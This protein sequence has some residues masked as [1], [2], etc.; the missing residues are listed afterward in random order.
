MVAAGAAVRRRKASDF[1]VSLTTPY[2]VTSFRHEPNAANIANVRFIE[3]TDPLGGTE[4]LEYQWQTASLSPTAPA[5]EVPAGFEAW[6][7]RG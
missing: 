3:A 7:S 1:V 5:G 4:H 2:G 6:I